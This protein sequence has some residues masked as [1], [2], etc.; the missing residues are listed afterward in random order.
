MRQNRRFAVT[1]QLMG[2]IY[3]LLKYWYL[4]KARTQKNA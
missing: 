3:N 1:G 2:N 4:H